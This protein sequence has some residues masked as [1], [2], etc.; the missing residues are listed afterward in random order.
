MHEHSALLQFAHTLH[1]YALAFMGDCLHPSDHMVCKTIQS[2][3]GTTGGHGDPRKDDTI[4]GHR[5]LSWERDNA[6]GHGKQ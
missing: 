5:V 1:W 3:W 4:E 2:R 6:L